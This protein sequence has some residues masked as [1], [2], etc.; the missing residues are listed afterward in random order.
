MPVEMYHRIFQCRLYVLQRRA[1]SQGPHGETLAGRLGPAWNRSCCFT[2]ESNGRQITDSGNLVRS[3]SIS[4]SRLIGLQKRPTQK[5]DI[6]GHQPKHA[7][8][9]YHRIISIGLGLRLAWSKP[10]AKYAFEN[11]QWIMNQ[12]AV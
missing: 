12:L 7:N 6:E 5:Q 10:V 2:R 3:G 8:S 4:L 1:G 9:E 11:K